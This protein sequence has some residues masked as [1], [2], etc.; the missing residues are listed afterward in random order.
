M[1][2]TNCDNNDLLNNENKKVATGNI[3]YDGI[4]FTCTTDPSLDTVTT[5]SLNTVLLRLLNAVCADNGC[6]IYTVTYT[7]LVTSITTS[8]L[9]PNAVYRFPYSTKHL[10]SGTTAQYNDTTLHYDS[11]SGIKT[12]YAPE[13]EYLLVRAI[14]VD[15]I[16]IEAYSESYPR[17]IIYY[18]H[19]L[20]KTED[21]AIDRPGFITY[22]EDPDNNISAHFDWRNVLHR[23]WNLEAPQTGGVANA[24][25]TSSFNTF[26]Q[27]DTAADPSLLNPFYNHQVYFTDL[28]NQGTIPYMTTSFTLTTLKF[29][30]IQTA[31]TAV[32]RDFKTFVSYDT[33]LYLVG[34][35]E[36]EKPRFKN[37][38]IDK[39]ESVARIVG[40]AS[41]AP[42]EIDN[43]GVTGS[44]YPGLANVV[45]LTRSAE[46]IKIG[47]NAS[48][49]TFTG[50]TVREINIGHNNENIIIGAT[51]GIP[52]YSVPGKPSVRGFN[53]DIEIGNNN[54]HVMIADNNRA[55]RIG[56]SNIGVHF[57][58]YCYNVEIGNHNTQIFKDLSFNC[59]VEDWNELIVATSAQNLT[60]RSTNKNIQL[61]CING[62]G[63]PISISSGA[64]TTGSLVVSRMKNIPDGFKNVI[65]DVVNTNATV[66]ISNKSEN[67]WI[68]QSS[69]VF[70]EDYAENNIIR[71]SGSITLGRQA[72]NNIFINCWFV[73]AGDIFNNNEFQ[74]AENINI[75]SSFR[76]SKMI[77]AYY[78]TVGSNSSDLL[79]LHNCF[80]L[81]LGDNNT[82]AFLS[83][84]YKGEIGNNSTEITCRNSNNFSIGNAGNRIYLETSNNVEI[85]KGCV[86]I[87]LN[88]LSVILDVFRETS[89]GA[90]DSIITTQNNFYWTPVQPRELS[91]LNTNMVAS[92]DPLRSVIPTPATGESGTP[93]DST[94]ISTSLSTYLGGSNISCSG[95][96]I[97]NNC[98]LIYI[99]SSQN[100]IIGSN[101]KVI[102]LGTDKMV[103]YMIKIVNG[104]NDLPN[105]GYFNTSD[106]FVASA[107][108]V[109]N[110]TALVSANY[111]G[112]CNNNI[113]SANQGEGVVYGEIRLYGNSKHGNYFGHFD[114]TKVVLGGGG[115][116][117]PVNKLFRMNRLN[118]M[119]DANTTITLDTE[120]KQYTFYDGQYVW[121]QSI[122]SLGVLQTP[123]KLQ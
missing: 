40:S 64:D 23:R 111:G 39:S 25:Y 21:D 6:C 35:T 50:R 36:Q 95:T 55:L 4:S 121:E 69:N 80:D 88:S 76:K 93:N 22:R 53:D 30:V 1:G 42:I 98:E 63:N 89:S 20:D 113:V 99:A 75:K 38:H 33:P 14:A 27:E 13:T 112:G 77:N 96:N 59:K 61:V 56:H 24:N 68:C 104:I 45:F 19:T 43:A 81:N 79:F 16:A 119:N 58:R 57:N 90:K 122:N 83:S 29:G 116:T 15:K 26:F 72:V 73:K 34:T 48:G 74:N 101:T 106:V 91:V 108:T 97:G 118:R 5:D 62:A 52:D 103:R 41:A 46:N 11:G 60:V 17:D 10:I 109:A 7:S 87:Y 82:K 117:A 115:L 102:E 8:S 3:E 32:Y 67:I 28:N 105:S 9:I 12:S 86:D 51:A 54:R 110:I 120:H 94:A 85:G 47:Q 37:I 44:M 18:D 49:I 66:N 107:Y 123:T 2:C 31:M 71:G 84:S 70:L 114:I 78:C 92:G 65:A 100:N